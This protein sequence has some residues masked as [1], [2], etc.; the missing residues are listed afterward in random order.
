MEFLTDP[1]YKKNEKKYKYVNFQCQT[2]KK[3]ESLSIPH[4]LTQ[5]EILRFEEHRNENEHSRQMLTLRNNQSKRKDNK[6]YKR[7]FQR[8]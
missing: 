4:I 1:R 2:K 7:N 3:S 6:T 8:N 5:H